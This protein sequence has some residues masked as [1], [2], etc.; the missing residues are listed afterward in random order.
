MEGA[1]PRVDR[2][3]TPTT[4]RRKRAP[5][6]GLI[7]ALFPLLV[8]LA[9]GLSG[10]HASPDVSDVYGTWEGYNRSINRDARLSLTLEPDGTFIQ[11]YSGVFGLPPKSLEGTWTYDS[12][13]GEITLKPFLKF[14]SMNVDGYEYRVKD[15]ATLDFEWNAFRGLLLLDSAGVQIELEKQ[16]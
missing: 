8:L 16:E 1:D 9:V 2:G 15:E 10:C 11:S 12:Y 3:V 4:Q 14:D 6:I 13:Y 5:A 7:A